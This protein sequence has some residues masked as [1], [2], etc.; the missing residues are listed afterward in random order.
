[1]SLLHPPPTIPTFRTTHARL[2]HGHVSLRIPCCS[3]PHAC[4]SGI[5]L[6]KRM[7]L[8]CQELRL[9]ILDS[10]AVLSWIGQ[11][12]SRPPLPPLVIHG[13]LHIS[14]TP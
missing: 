6:L 9:R 1:M 10:L 4:T 7:R 5:Q 12:V 13:C 14:W 3:G 8:A 11:A 2:E